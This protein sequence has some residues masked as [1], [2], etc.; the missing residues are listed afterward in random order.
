MI[1]DGL[2]WDGKGGLAWVE[3]GWIGVEW[4]EIGGLGWVELGWDGMIWMGW[5]G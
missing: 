5:V 1:W 4:D 2:E 3:L